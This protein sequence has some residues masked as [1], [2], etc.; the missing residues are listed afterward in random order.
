ML[1]YGLKLLGSR[2]WGNPC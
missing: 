2:G 1:I